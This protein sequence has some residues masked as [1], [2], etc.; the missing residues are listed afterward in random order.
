MFVLLAQP[1]L[2]LRPRFDTLQ[3]WPPVFGVGRGWSVGSRTSR[4]RGRDVQ[5]DDSYLRIGRVWT[6]LQPVTLQLTLGMYS[7]PI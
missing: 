4:G 3:H 6:L 2:P 5:W 7:V 1:G